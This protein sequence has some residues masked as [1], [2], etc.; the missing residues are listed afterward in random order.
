MKKAVSIAFFALAA[1]LAFGAEISIL[2]TAFGPGDTR[3]DRAIEKFTADFPAVNVRKLVVDLSDG[4]TMTMDAMLAAGKAPNV[5]MDTL[6][7]SSKYMVPEFAADLKPLVRDLGT[8]QKGSL[9]AFTKGGKLLGLPI[10]GGAQGM[11][12]NLDI[13]DEIGYTVPDR[14]TIADFLTMAELVKQKYQGKKWAT[15]MFA[16]NQSGDYLINNWF[17]A[18]GTKYYAPGDYSKTTIAKGSG[19]ADTYKFFQT[20]A[21]KGYIPPGS[22]TLTDDDYAADWAM[23]RYAATA[24]FVGWMEGYWKTAM[25]QGGIAKP[26]RVK[27]VPFPRAPSVANV[28]SYSSSAAMV[29]R[30]TGTEQDLWAGRLV[31]YLNDSEAQTISVKLQAN[32]PNRTDVTATPGDPYTAQ[33]AKIVSAGGIMDVGLTNAKFAATRPVHYPILQKVLTGKI[34]PDVAVKEYEAA[35]NAA[36]K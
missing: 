3:L 10:P 9:D 35:L 12:I 4:S 34:T 1:F 28:P 15:G 13:M 11:C 23:G 26:F 19:A 33:I 18:F 29:V 8:Y 17:F 22:A 36:L 20:L 30:K 5:Y 32:I 31:E 24:F 6:V 25:E 14:W 2:Y 7:R 16:A 27:Y 21:T